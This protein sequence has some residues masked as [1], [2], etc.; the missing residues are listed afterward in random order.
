MFLQINHHPTDQ[1]WNVEVSGQSRVRHVAELALDQFD[2]DEGSLRFV[3]HD[4]EVE[5]DEEL[6]LSEALED[7]ELDPSLTRLT[8]D[9]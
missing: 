9:V 5:L 8:I 6:T 7:F 3:D 2:L 1:V 4:D